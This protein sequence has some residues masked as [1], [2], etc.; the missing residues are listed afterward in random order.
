[1]TYRICPEPGIAAAIYFEGPKLRTLSWQL[2][3]P[4]ELEESWSVEHELARKRVH[5]EWLRQEIGKPP[6]Q[7]PWGRLESNYDP[8][9]CTSAII[10]S[11]VE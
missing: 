2:E 3:L 7:F 4:P 10:V 1:M 5:D 9:G 8:K 6:Y 11:Y